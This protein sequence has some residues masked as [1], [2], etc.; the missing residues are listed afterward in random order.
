MI[1]TSSGMIKNE[2]LPRAGVV[3]LNSLYD[4]FYQDVI[5]NGIDIGWESA[6]DELRDSMPDATEDA[7]DEA[8]QEL[9]DNWESSDSTYLIGDWVKDDSGK[10]SIDPTGPMG[11]A[12]EFSSGSQNVTI[13][14]SRTVTRCMH[15]SPCY[16]MADGS[17]P[18]GNLDQVDSNGTVL[19]FDLP[20]DYRRDQSETA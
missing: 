20:S 13:E 19:A 18:C 4:D 14:Y 9:G 7:I 5:L 1:N 2:E 17:G 8:L 10:Y 6:V 16:V 3:S 12:G 15:T 11:F